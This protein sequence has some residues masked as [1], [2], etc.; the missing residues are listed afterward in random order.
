MYGSLTTTSVTVGGSEVV[1]VF[2]FTGSRPFA[3]S[4]AAANGRVIFGDVPS[5]SAPLGSSASHLP[6]D[7]VAAAVLPSAASTSASHAVDVGEILGARLA[8]GE[9]LVEQAARRVVVRRTRRPCA[10]P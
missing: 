1:S 4:C 7:V 2:T 8:V 6:N 9:R 5:G 3:W 10:H